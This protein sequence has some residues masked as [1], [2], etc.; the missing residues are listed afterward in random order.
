MTNEMPKSNTPDQ[1]PPAWPQRIDPLLKD[2][3]Y[4]SESDE[5][6]EGVT[7]YLDGEAPLTGSQI[8]DWLMLPPSVYV[9]E[10]SEDEFW[11]LPT[12][13]EDWHGDEER[14]RASRF[15]E[16]KK[17]V[18]ENLTVRQLFRVGDT[19]IDVYLLGRTADGSRAGL[20]TK[21]V[22]T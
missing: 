8:E 13:Q 1:T 10:G 2:L 14:E 22:E 3:L 19:E 9:E 16:L 17:I 15:I 20:K 4:P 6:I 18:E 5:P 7:C 21:V 12:R 11:D